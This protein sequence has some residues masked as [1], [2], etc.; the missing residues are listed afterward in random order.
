MSCG[1]SWRHGLGLALLWLW[2][3]L[4]ATALI[5]LLAWDLPY[6]SG[7]A[8]KRPKSKLYP[9]RFSLKLLA[10]HQ[11]QNPSSLPWPN[12]P[13]CGS[14]LLPQLISCHSNPCSYALITLAPFCSWNRLGLSVPWGP[15]T[16]TSL[17]TPSSLGWLLSHPSQLK[18]NPY[19]KA[20]PLSSYLKWCSS[21]RHSLFY[22][23]VLFFP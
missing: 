4:M 20:A 7:R 18:L 13:T 23:P 12:D 1:T 14:C 5:R 22:Y 8:L 9:D 15:W 10:F 19:L 11:S 21:L 6:A 3:R 16:W 17:Y 2:H